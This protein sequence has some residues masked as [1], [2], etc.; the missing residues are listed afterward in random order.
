MST[1]NSDLHFHGVNVY[2]NNTVRQCGGALVLTVDSKMYL[3]E[4]TQMYVLNNTALKYGG[5]ICVD[6]GVVPHLVDKCFWQLFNPDILSKNDTFVHFEGNR[7]PITGHAIYAGSAVNCNSEISFTKQ[8]NIIFAL[9][10]HVF[11]VEYQDTSPLISWYQMSSQPFTVCF[12][13]PEPQII[14]N[15]TVVPNISVYPGQTFQVLAVGM[16][17]GISSAV[18]RSRINI[19]NIISSLKFKVWEMRVNLSTTQS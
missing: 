1:Y 6:G 8:A 11:Q 14:C 3:H 19:V 15:G 16:G 5:G 2:E 10:F 17:V 18:V 12:C 9:F 4:G 7:A 13:Y